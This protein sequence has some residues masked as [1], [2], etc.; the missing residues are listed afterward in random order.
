MHMKKKIIILLIF[1]IPIIAVASYFGGISIRKHV[2]AKELADA[3]N[4]DSIRYVGNVNPEIDGYQVDRISYVTSDKCPGRYIWIKKQDGVLVTNYMNVLYGDELIEYTKEYFKDKFPCDRC[5]F[6]ETFFAFNCEVGVTEFDDMPL[7]CG[8]CLYYEDDIPTEDEMKEL[9]TEFAKTERRECL[10][11]IYVQN[12]GEEPG[13]PNTTEYMLK[14]DH[15]RI[16]KLLVYH[17][18]SGSITNRTSEVLIE[19]MKLD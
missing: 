12:E 15:D 8:I 10:I 18:G 6:K 1:L 4:D 19:D 2:W 11:Y 17:I 3:Y 16:E 13:G 7:N 9:I 5:D 14:M